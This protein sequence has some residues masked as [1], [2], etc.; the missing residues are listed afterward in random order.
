LDGISQIV[1][2][3]SMAMGIKLFLENDL[4]LG[5]EAGNKFSKVYLCLGVPVPTNHLYHMD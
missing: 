4:T 3:I 1:L 2:V 5:L